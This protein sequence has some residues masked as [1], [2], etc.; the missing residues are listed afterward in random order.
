MDQS[1][2]ERYVVLAVGDGEGA[3]RV[4]ACAREH[5]LR[6]DLIPDPTSQLAKRFRVACWPTAVWIDERGLV[7]GL[8]FGA[9][10]DRSPREPGRVEG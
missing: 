1:R 8:H 5:G 6:F 7:E 3:A 4:R 10:P 9:T 2:E